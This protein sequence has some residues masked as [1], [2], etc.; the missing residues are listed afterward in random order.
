MAAQVASAGEAVEVA[1]QEHQQVGAGGMVASDAFTLWL[2][3]DINL[4]LKHS[5]PDL[6]RL[7]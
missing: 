5:L 7:I 6:S 2:G 4:W 3:E 1:G